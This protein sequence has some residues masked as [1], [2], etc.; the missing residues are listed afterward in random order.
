MA[1]T[2]LAPFDSFSQPLARAR[3]LAISAR[4]ITHDN[5]FSFFHCYLLPGSEYRTWRVAS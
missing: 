1:R 2:S 5:A 4:I 3:R